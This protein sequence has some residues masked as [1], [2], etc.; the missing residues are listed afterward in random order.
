MIVDF[1]PKYRVSNSFDLHLS[2]QL[3]LAYL[4]IEKPRFAQ[5]RGSSI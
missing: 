1:P 4:N 2:F 5:E 3:S